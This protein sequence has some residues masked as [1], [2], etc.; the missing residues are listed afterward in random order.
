[1]YILHMKRVTA[2]EA[3]RNWFRLLDEVAAGATVVIERH[4]RRIVL[5]R[6]EISPEE[7]DLPDYASIIRV[8]DAERADEWRW[9]WPG[10]EGA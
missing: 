3:R 8:P 6:E 9:D 5:S 10:E 4:G 7:K 2:S 1:M